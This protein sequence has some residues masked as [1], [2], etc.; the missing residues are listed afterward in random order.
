MRLVALLNRGF[1][2]AAVEQ[3]TTTVQVV[4]TLTKSLHLL[5][6]CLSIHVLLPSN[7]AWHA[8]TLGSHAN[9]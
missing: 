1:A 3:P 6:T 2:A 5:L 9:V 8:A 7:G 4:D